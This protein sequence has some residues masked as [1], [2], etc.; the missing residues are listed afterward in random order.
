MDALRESL[1]LR[2]IYL[3]A[4]LEKARAS[5]Q[6]TPPTENPFS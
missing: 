2:L 6:R 5:Y 3:P 1:P 4:D